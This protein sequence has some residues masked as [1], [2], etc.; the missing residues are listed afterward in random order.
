MVVYVLF[1]SDASNIYG[2]IG[3]LFLDKNV[4]YKK[5]GLGFGEFK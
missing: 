2:R 5:S 3:N 4:T 1:R